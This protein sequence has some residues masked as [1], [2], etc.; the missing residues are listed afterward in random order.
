M[1]Y[2]TRTAR[3]TARKSKYNIFAVFII[4]ILLLYA[5]LTWILPVF[6]NSLGFV[7]GVF[8]KEEK[9]TQVSDNPTLAPPVLSIP[10]E[11]TSSAQIDIGGYA[12]PG[13]KVKIYVDDELKDTVDVQPDGS[14]VANNIDLNLGTNNI[15]GKTID[16]K[17]QESL[18]SKTIKLVYDS[19]KP[20]L[21]VS[22][23]EDGK[24]VQGERKLKVAG[25]TEPGSQVTVNGN[26]VIVNSDGNFSTIFNLNDGENS[27]TIRASD[28][29]SNMTEI[30]RKVTFNP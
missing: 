21:E 17:D 4:S 24:T 13:S 20:S 2:R 22:E 16:E 8:N 18:A 9:V 19:E 30:T 15:Y 11:A 5:T 7:T 29:A 6:V 1:A 12:T 27:L 28:Q 10:Y 14:F 25:K 26:Q 3:R 23:P